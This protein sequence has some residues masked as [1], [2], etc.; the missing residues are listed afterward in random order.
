MSILEGV[1]SWLCFFKILINVNI[2]YVG[3]CCCTFVYL[4][5]IFYAGVRYYIKQHDLILKLLYKILMLSHVKAK[6]HRIL[7]RRTYHFCII[8]NWNGNPHIICNN[9]LLH[10]FFLKFFK[11]P[12]RWK[13]FFLKLITFLLL[14][15]YTNSFKNNSKLRLVTRL[16]SF[17]FYFDLTV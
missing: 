6:H 1:R 14:V 4:F 5:T 12:V 13:Q 9:E 7:F 15:L 11:F 2:V 3:V 16:Y 8:S 10:C 17:Y